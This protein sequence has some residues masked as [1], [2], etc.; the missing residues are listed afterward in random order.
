MFREIILGS[1]WWCS[2]SI[3]HTTTEK[4]LFVA[5]IIFTATIILTNRKQF[6]LISLLFLNTCSIMDSGRSETG[7]LAHQ[8]DI[9][10][11]FCT[12][13]HLFSHWKRIPSSH[14]HH[15]EQVSSYI[16]KWLDS[17][18]Y[19]VRRRQNVIGMWL[20]NRKLIEK[21]LSQR[22]K[23]RFWMKSSATN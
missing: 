13:G 15:T 16:Q 20:T 5:I 22:G 2:E 12:A 10:L 1:G 14:D 21:K 8:I 19:E 11:P 7:K 23:Q 18:L 9:K 17:L 6:Q 4:K 3:I